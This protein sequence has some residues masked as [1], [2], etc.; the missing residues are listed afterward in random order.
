MPWGSCSSHRF[1]RCTHPACAF[2]ASPRAVPARPAAP[3]LR[4]PPGVMMAPGFPR[5]L[6][7][8]PTGCGRLWVARNV[9]CTA[10]T[11]IQPVLEVRGQEG[12]F[13]GRLHGVRGQSCPRERPFLSAFPALFCPGIP[14][15]PV[16]LKCPGVSHPGVRSL[17]T[18]RTFTSNPHHPRSF[19]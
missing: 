11:W 4:K 17:W 7:H 3:W 18:G 15:S 13:L 10:P 16:L 5:P 19:P 9:F 2:S 8:G 12:G 14:S 1:P 6:G